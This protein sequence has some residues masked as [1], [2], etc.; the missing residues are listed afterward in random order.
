MEG[1]RVT[2]KQFFGVEC[3]CGRVL[4]LDASPTLP[5]RQDKALTN[6]PIESP[7]Q[8]HCK[9]WT[10]IDDEALTK[11]VQSNFGM[12]TYPYAATQLGRTIDSVKQRAH[13]LGLRLGVP[14]PVALPTTPK[15]KKVLLIDHVREAV[16]HFDDVHRSFTSRDV[17]NYLKRSSNNLN[18]QLRE[19]WL[20]ENSRLHKNFER[21]LDQVNGSLLPQYVF[22]PRV[23]EFN[24]KAGGR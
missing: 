9:P 4:L 16:A 12:D 13:V 18:I 3:S 6:E 24:E 14:G 17:S 1:F 7:L 22:I 11:M 2:P 15:P 20:D 21:Q 8:K 10:T 5:T 19:L 23:L